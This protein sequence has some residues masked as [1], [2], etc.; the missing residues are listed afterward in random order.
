MGVKAFTYFLLQPWHC[1]GCHPEDFNGQKRKIFLHLLDLWLR[2]WEQNNSLARENIVH[3]FNVSSMW[4]GSLQEWKKQT[5][6]T[7]VPKN[8]WRTKGYDLMVCVLR[9]LSKPI[10]T[11]ASWNLFSFIPL[12]WVWDDS[13]GIKVLQPTFNARPENS[14][15]VCIRR[16]WPEKSVRLAASADFF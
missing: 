5:K 8:D 2:P 7:M 3:V 13:F 9:I 4:H 12:P 1:V 16:K 6:N 11:G 15:T 14:F 10:Y